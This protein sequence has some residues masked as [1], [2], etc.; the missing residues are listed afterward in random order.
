M[1]EFRGI[2]APKAVIGVKPRELP[3]STDE[4]KSKAI[5]KIYLPSKTLRD[6]FKAACA[7]NATS[8][9]ETIV[10][11]VQQYVEEHEASHHRSRPLSGHEENL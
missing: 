5:L 4:D 11:F 3:V 8:M 2:I 7:L 10:E 1:L 6:R 9:N